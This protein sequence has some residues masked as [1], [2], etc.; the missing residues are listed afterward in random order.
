MLDHLGRENT[1]LDTLL[2]FGA[3]VIKTQSVSETI[4]QINRQSL[5]VIFSRFVGDKTI[6]SALNTDDIEWKKCKKVISHRAYS[7]TPAHT[8]TGELK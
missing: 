3:Y 1:L 5:F 2:K 4:I 8:F 7:Y 6:Q